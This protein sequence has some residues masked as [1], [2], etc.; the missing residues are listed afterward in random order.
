MGCN[1]KNNESIDSE[2]VEA[3]KLYKL[4]KYWNK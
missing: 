1:L 2:I 3:M 4:F